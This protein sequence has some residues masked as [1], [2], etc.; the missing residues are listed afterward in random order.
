MGKVYYNSLR[1]KAADN[2]RF[3]KCGI[4]GTLLISFEVAHCMQAS[5]RRRLA[6]AKRKQ[7]VKERFELRHDGVGVQD[8]A[9]R[10][11]DGLRA[12]RHAQDQR[13]LGG[14]QD[15]QAD[16]PVERYRG[17]IAWDT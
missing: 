10:V 17:E 4:I 8:E 12:V 1:T 5:L 7:T 2:I 9:V 6:I 15:H 16:E 3:A 13:Q 11:G 14:G